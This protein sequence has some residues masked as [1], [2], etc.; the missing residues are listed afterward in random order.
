MQ[1]NGDHASADFQ[2]DDLFNIRRVA[3]SYGVTLRALRFYEDRGLINPIRR[4]STRLYDP[5]TLSRLRL[6]LKGKQ[7]GFT[8][9]EISEMLAANDEAPSPAFDLAL[10]ADKV[11]EQLGHLERQR[12]TIERA[13][14]ELK[15]THERLARRVTGP[16]MAVANEFAP[17]AAR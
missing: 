13:I 8:L 10:G 17:M 2:E 1:I 16:G 14:A 9:S 12:Q 3:D 6:I 15:A 5:R 11:A 7:F 4:G